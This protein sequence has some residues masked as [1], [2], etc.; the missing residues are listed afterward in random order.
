MFPTIYGMALQGLGNDSKF[1]AAGL[2]M[3]I[4][5]GALLPMVHAAVM[6]VARSATGY[7]VPGICLALVAL[8]AVFD[9]RNPRP[10]PGA[11]SA[12]EVTV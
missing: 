8:Y 4:L 12:E 1:G 7:V 9:L 3:A 6:D 11:A 5:G 10:Q 2:V